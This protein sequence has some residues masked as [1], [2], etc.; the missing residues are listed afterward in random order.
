M[1]GSYIIIFSLLPFLIRYVYF[2]KTEI[3]GCFFLNKCLKNPIILYDE[4]CLLEWKGTK[5]SVFDGSELICDD[6]VYVRDIS[7]K[8]ALAFGKKINLNYA[9][10]DD[11]LLLPG[12]GEKL[13]LEIYS[14][15]EKR[16]R[17][18]EIDE[19]IKVKGI[20]RKKLEKLKEY[21][22]VK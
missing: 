21:V 11:I 7:G 6:K 9:D 5:V 14:I 18:N 4:D 16:G 2:S 1:K 8:E 15:R 22:T 17:F 13:A 19:L 12:I 3:K 10:I 20:G